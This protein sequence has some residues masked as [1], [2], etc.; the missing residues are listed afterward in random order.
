MA[1]SEKNQTTSTRHE[2]FCETCKSK[3]GHDKAALINFACCGHN[4]T[5]LEALYRSEPSPSGA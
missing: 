4:L 2:F 5:K 3:Y 1:E